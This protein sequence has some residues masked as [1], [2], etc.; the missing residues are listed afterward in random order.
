MVRDRRAW[1]MSKEMW[2]WLRGRRNQSEAI[3]EALTLYREMLE[4]PN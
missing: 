3:R 4:T 1:S 2:E